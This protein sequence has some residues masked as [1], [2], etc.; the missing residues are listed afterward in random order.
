MPA[1][2]AL[3]LLRR[4]AELRGQLTIL[5]VEQRSELALSL[6]ETAVVLERGR[7]AFSGASCERLRDEAAQQRW[8][9]VGGVP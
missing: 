4:L 5:L 3:G 1:K 2:L 9:G 6:A 7:I 8:L